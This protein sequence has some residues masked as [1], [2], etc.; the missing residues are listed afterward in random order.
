MIPSKVDW[1]IVTLDNKPL[2]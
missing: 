2:S 1:L